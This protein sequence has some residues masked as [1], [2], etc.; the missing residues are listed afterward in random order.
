MMQSMLMPQSWNSSCH[1]C[2]TRRPLEIGGGSN[3]ALRHNDVSIAPEPVARTGPSNNSHSLVA[4]RRGNRATSSD[5]PVISGTTSVASTRL[6]PSWQSGCFSKTPFKALAR[7]DVSKLAE[8]KVATAER[9][10]GVCAGRLP[11]VN[12][13]CPTGFFL[14]YNKKNL[15]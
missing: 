6:V 2:S 8:T 1:I 9:L 4:T 12:P 3:D 13:T 11:F 7:G 10:A 14:K 15:T 5:A